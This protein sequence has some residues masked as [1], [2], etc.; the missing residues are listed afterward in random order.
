MGVAKDI[1]QAFEE[2]QTACET[3]YELGECGKCPMVTY[4]IRED[5]VSF[6]EAIYNASFDSIKGFI[7]YAERLT[8]I[9]SVGCVGSVGGTFND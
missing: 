3:I 5:R 1:Y 6:G 9:G 4:C 8:D 7:E 2:L